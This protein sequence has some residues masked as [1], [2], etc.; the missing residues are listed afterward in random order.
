MSSD[1]IRLEDSW[2]WLE[3]SDQ[4]VSCPLR[5]HCSHDQYSFFNS[6]PAFQPSLWPWSVGFWESAKYSSAPLIYLLTHRENDLR[7]WYFKGS[8]ICPVYSPMKF[9]ITHTMTF[10]LKKK[11]ILI[12]FWELRALVKKVEEPWSEKVDKSLHLCWYW[13]AFIR[14]LKEKPLQ[15]RQQPQSLTL[16]PGQEFP[17]SFSTFMCLSKEK[18]YFILKMSWSLLFL[19][20][21]QLG[22]KTPTVSKWF[23]G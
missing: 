19:D 20:L 2:S 7:V 11:K 1:V 3:A 10:K 18:K 21:N 4:A 14:N 15:W 5:P 13:A 22:G 12:L 9:Q 8:H 17:G 16:L 6:G 23:F